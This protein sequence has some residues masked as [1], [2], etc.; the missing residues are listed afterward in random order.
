[1]LREAGPQVQQQSVC[2]RDDASSGQKVVPNRVPNERQAGG[3][4]PGGCPMGVH[5]AFGSC[6]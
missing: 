3:R 2:K 5:K 4:S 1:M 6:R